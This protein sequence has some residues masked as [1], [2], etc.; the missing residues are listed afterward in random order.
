L[1]GVGEDRHRGEIAR[2]IH[3]AGH[4][5]HVGRAPVGVEGDGAEGVAEDVASKAELFTFLSGMCCIPI[6]TRHIAVRPLN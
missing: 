6:R 5:R 2:L 1:K 4:G 3:A